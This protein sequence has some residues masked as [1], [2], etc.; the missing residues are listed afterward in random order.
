M[1]EIKI[2]IET[3]IKMGTGAQTAFIVWCIK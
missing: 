3:L 2:I 1:E